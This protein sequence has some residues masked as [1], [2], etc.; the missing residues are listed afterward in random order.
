MRHLIAA[1]AVALILGSCSPPTVRQT[2]EGYLGALARVDFEGAS[3]YV[4]AEGRANFDLLRRLYSSLSPAEQKKFQFTD[5]EVTAES[6]TGDSATVDFTFDGVKKGQLVL[7]QVGGVW[8][9]D[10]RQT[11]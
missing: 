5:W 4:S 6:V 8:K 7:K 2:A 10:H 11:F 3:R 9:V 1:L